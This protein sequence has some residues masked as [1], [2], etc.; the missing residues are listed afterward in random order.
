M[1]L[2]IELKKLFALHEASKR[3]RHGM[4]EAQ[5]AN[6]EWREFAP[7][8]FVYAFFTFNSIY[9]F[10]WQRSFSEK[11]ALPWEPDKNERLPKEE[12]QIK[13][14][15][16]FADGQ[17]APDTSALM[18]KGVNQMLAE[19]GVGNAVEALRSI[20]LVNPTKTLR[21]LAGPIPTYTEKLL[22]GKIAP[23]DL[24]ATLSHMLRFVYLVRCNILHGVKT[25]VEMARPDQQQRLLVY[26]ALVIAS[27]GL[28]FD[29][30]RRADIG[31]REVDVDFSIK[32][33]QPGVAA[34]ALQAARR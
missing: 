14:Y 25:H 33:A 23:N 22:K 4:R 12:E 30:A 26:C 11:K 27:N 5:S 6:S 31:W 10:D 20:D 3:L 21:S 2:K 18:T 16:E 8:R 1:D 19:F 13:S 9:S 28:L 34:D 29:I 15:V 32:D 17:L 24:Y 7:S